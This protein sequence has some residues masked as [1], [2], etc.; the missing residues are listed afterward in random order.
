MQ[1]PNYIESGTKGFQPQKSRT[2]FRNAN[3]ALLVR[4]SIFKLI[5]SQFPVRL[6]I[7]IN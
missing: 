3:T 7:H 1:N 4:L 6:W 5:K 2:I